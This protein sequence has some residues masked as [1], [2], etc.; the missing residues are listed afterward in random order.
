MKRLIYWLSIFSY[1]L[2][3]TAC[4]EEEPK[5]S[6]KYSRVTL[7]NQA[8]GAAFTTLAD[9]NN[10]GKLDIV[11][12][13]FGPVKDI[14]TRGSVPP[15]EISIYY[16]GNSLTEWN[17]E[18]VLSR[19]AGVRLTQELVIEDIDEDG[20]LDIGVGTGF[21]ICGIL[22]P[23]GACGGVL[24]FEQRN[25]A[26]AKHE[27]LSPNQTAFYHTTLFTDLDG[28]GTKDLI[29]VAEDR[30]IKE[31]FIEEFAR[32]E[33]FRGD[34]TLGDL[35]EPTPRIIG[36]GGGSLPQ[37]YD[38]DG[39][40]DLDLVS[41]EYFAGLGASFT[42][43]EQ[44]TAPVAGADAS[45]PNAYVGEWTRHIIDDQSGPSIQGSIVD[46]FLKNQDMVL[47]GANHTNT[48]K[49]SDDPKEGIFLYTPTDDLKSP[50][51][52]RLISN[53][54]QSAT[55]EAG[56]AAP[57]IFGW[58]DLENDGDL[59][60]IVN[61]DAD[62]RIFLIEQK[63]DT[64]I[65]HVLD[66]GIPQGGGMKIAD[67]NGNGVKELVVTHFEEDSIYL[68]V[69]DPAGQYPL[70]TLGG[71]D[72]ITSVESLPKKA[73]FNIKYEGFAQGVLRIFWYAGTHSLTELKEQTAL[74]SQVLNDATFP[75]S[76]DLTLNAERYTV[77]V[78]LDLGAES[79]N[80]PGEE[81]LVAFRSFTPPSISRSSLELGLYEEE[82]PEE[83]RA[84]GRVK[85]T[86]NYDQ[87]LP[88]MAPPGGFNVV[89]GFY[90]DQPIDGPPGFPKIQ[91]VDSFP[92]EV[93][94]EDIPGGDYFIYA[95]LDLV[96]P[97]SAFYVDPLD[98]SG[99]SAFFEVDGGEA[100]V[101]VDLSAP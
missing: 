1:L 85:I 97:Y 65:T 64:F 93:I 43:Y 42:W 66:D 58:G 29:T 78:Y 12:S 80:F 19:D 37:L 91:V 67:L 6:L 87:V 98:P 90:E 73:E 46:G 38:V 5:V 79:L 40:G 74:D 47:I 25:N 83:T 4:S 16:Q 34:P 31:G 49:N 2:F 14:L 52:R 95:F 94:Y 22:S 100:N 36:E 39:D 57:G 41:A 68:Y 69:N 59:D 84:A 53:G 82:Q 63:D 56:Q 45:N 61:G 30:R 48:Q 10:D 81:D 60:L 8:Y 26:W 92:T 44:V 70:E 32:V 17:V 86:L 23:G 13:H 21:L 77:L 99:E 11:V 72:E 101:T 7:D 62:D 33:W 15:A 89:T 71:P 51:N 75:Y 54:I 55:A 18:V 96:E 20:D 50:W 9:M 88:M 24:W 27:V 28:D 76:L 35:F 3:L